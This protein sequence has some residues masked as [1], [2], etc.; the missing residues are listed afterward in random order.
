MKTVGI[1]LAAGRGA[2]MGSLGTAIPKGLLKIDGLS[3]IERQ[4]NALQACKIKNI[5]A[6]VG[7]SANKVKRA[8]GSELKYIVNPRWDTANN[9]YSL[10]LARK[11]ADKGFILI[12]SDDLFHQGILENLI[13][14]NHLDAISID[15]SKQLGDEE[16]K[17]TLKNGFLFEINKTMDAKTAYGEYIGIAK[18]SPEGSKEL[19]TV[20]DDF[21]KHDDVHG[22]YEEAFEVL[23]RRR[24]I[25]AVSTEGLPWIEIDTPDDFERAEKKIMPAI[26]KKQTP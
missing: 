18:F 24:P 3:L 16:I 21:I 6:V 23:G 17:V 2:R 4:I 26:A 22:W 1:I 9:I 7:F 12:N 14:N 5:Y 25:A 19:F 20:L 10:Y 15:D 13:K 8:F 11:I